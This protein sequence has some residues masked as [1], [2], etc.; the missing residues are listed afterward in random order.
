MLLFVKKETFLFSYPHSSSEAVEAFRKNNK[1]SPSVEEATSTY[2]MDLVYFLWKT[3]FSK[4]LSIIFGQE[5]FCF[6]VK[7]HVSTKR[8]EFFS[9]R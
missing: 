7:K 4:P 1:T 6:L 2:K 5:R 9:K 8:E 3:F